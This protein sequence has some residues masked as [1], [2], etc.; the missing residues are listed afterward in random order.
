M[1]LRQHNQ[2]FAHHALVVREAS[3]INVNRRSISNPTTELLFVCNVV[4]DAPPYHGEAFS[5]AGNMFQENLLEALVGAG[6]PPTLVLSQ[7]PIRL[8]PR[9]RNF[10]VCASN[11][12]LRNNMKVRLVPYLNAPIFRPL[13]VGVG[14][15]LRSIV[16]GY[17]NRHTRNKVICIYNLTEPPGLFALL[18]ARV[19]GATA[20][21]FIIDINVPGQTVPPTLSRRLDF[22]L[23]KRLIPCFDGLV[24]VSKK[25]ID[26][27]APSRPH[28]RI[29]GGINKAYIETFSAP[30]LQTPASSSF[31]I[32]AVGS[33]DE[34]NG[35]SEI[36]AAFSLLKGN[37]FKLEIAGVGPLEEKVKAAAASDERIVYHGFI[38]FEEV[39][40]LYKRA[41]VL[42]N[43]RLTKRIDTSYFFPSK[44]FEYLA[45]GVPVISTGTGHVEAELRDLVFLL[46]DESAE[47]LAG[48]IEAVANLEPAVRA[49]KG[50]SAQQYMSKHCT[51]EAQ[52]QRVADFI[53]G[54]VWEK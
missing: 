35:F 37:K 5:R 34:A 43:M 10:W 49:Q 11:V 41:D 32:V 27:F 54:R 4:P 12:T 24:V 52:G 31:V 48:V 47:G 40:V 29:E 53:R 28:I 13:T 20:I 42:V 7:R 9:S 19:L 36:L 8:F 51:W 3:F 15:L 14:V 30:R 39:A 17:N 18:S 22:W 50:V 23:Q 33:L 21:A 38:S 2:P 45:S 26:D 6:L 1:Q 46:K 25:I 44:M 16:W